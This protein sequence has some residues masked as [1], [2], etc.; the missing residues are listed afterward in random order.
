MN[1]RIKIRY[2]TTRVRKHSIV[3]QIREFPNKETDGVPTS[4]AIK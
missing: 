4:D 3:E 1:E 2:K